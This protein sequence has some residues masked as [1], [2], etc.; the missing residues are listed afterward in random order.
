MWLWPVPPECQ[1]ARR[2]RCRLGEGRVHGACPCPELTGAAAGAATCHGGSRSGP[3]GTFRPRGSCLSPE[4]CFRHP[5]VPAKGT[6]VLSPQGPLK[7]LARVA[8]VWT[9]GDLPGRPRDPVGEHSALHP[10]PVSPRAEAAG[11]GGSIPRE[12]ALGEVGTPARCDV[13]GM[14]CGWRFPET[15]PTG[16][17]GSPSFPFGVSS[18]ATGVFAS[19]AQR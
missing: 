12:V 2:A 16:S 17:D 10:P 15:G 6:R 13:L 7:R 8:A 3:C 11:A 18:C 19:H 4:P 5:Y 9:I 14:P 1:P